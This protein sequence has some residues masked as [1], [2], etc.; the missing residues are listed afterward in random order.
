MDH[1]VHDVTNPNIATFVG[2]DHSAIFVEALGEKLDV[3][4]RGSVVPHFHRGRD[5]LI[6]VLDQLD[7]V[8]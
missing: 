7:D 1:E 4:G 8:R 6:L 5:L 2:V 3:Q